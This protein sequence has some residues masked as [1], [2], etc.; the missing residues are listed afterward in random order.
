[1]AGGLPYYADDEDSY[2]SHDSDAPQPD[3]SFSDGGTSTLDE[4]GDLPSDAGEYQPAERSAEKERLPVR[5]G[6]EFRMLLKTMVSSVAVAA[7]LAGGIGLASEENRMIV[8]RG[9][10]VLNL[11]SMSYHFPEERIR[12]SEPI[13]ADMV[14]GQVSH[15]LTKQDRRLEEAVAGECLIAHLDPSRGIRE[16]IRDAGCES[17]RSGM[18]VVR[19]VDGLPEEQGR[20]MASNS[21]PGV[22]YFPIREDSGFLVTAHPSATGCRTYAVTPEGRISYSSVTHECGTIRNSETQMVG[23][24]SVD[25]ECPDGRFVVLPESPGC[26]RPLSDEQLEKFTRRKEPRT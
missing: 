8:E 10:Q 9:E 15:Y 16:I 25:E 13:P 20:A 7:V 1:M 22:V 3:L 11:F 5:R 21:G 23:Y 6:G 19:V 18:Q 14:N 17:E 4:V 24:L 2:P 12:N 26:I